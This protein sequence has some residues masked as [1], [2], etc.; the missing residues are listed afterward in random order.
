MSL[1]NGRYLSRNHTRRSKAKKLSILLSLIIIFNLILISFI[2]SSPFDSFDKEAHDENTYFT[3]KT[4]D[5]PSDVFDDP[6]T[7]NFDDVW[8]FFKTNFRSN[9]TPATIDTYYREGDADGD[10]SEYLVYS[11]ENLL[12]YNTL[13]KYNQSLSSSQIYDAYLDLKSTNLWY[14][15]E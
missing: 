8:N 6:Y 14:D 3:P 11:L 5:V 7:Q 15:G 10:L 9:F 4:Q 13:K 1:K 2:N 12:L